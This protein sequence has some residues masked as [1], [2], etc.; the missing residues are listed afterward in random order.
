MGKLYYITGNQEQVREQVYG[1]ILQWSRI[2]QMQ[3][4]QPWSATEQE[5]EQEQANF[6]LYD[7]L[8]QGNGEMM[9]QLIATYGEDTV[10]IIYLRSPEETETQLFEMGIYKSYDPY[11]NLPQCLR[12]IVETVF[13]G[14]QAVN[15]DFAAALQQEPMQR[16]QYQAQVDM[17]NT[18]PQPKPKKKPGKLALRILAVIVWVAVVSLLTV[19]I[20]GAVT[21]AEQ[22]QGK[23]VTVTAELTQDSL[24]N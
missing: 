24:N 6:Y 4:L 10:E 3:P 23:L 20:Y 17:Q 12:E 15:Y 14:Y 18:D 9:A 13:T 16:H 5:Q 21:Q 7:Y 11:T 22:K 2:Q 19:C 1:A 8:E